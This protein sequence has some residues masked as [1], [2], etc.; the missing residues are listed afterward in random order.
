MQIWMLYLTTFVANAA[1]LIFEI[2][3]ARFLAPYIGTSYEVWAGLISVILGS[4]AF[5]YWLGGRIADRGATRKRLAGIVFLA[6]G[7]GI[8]MWSVREIVPLLGMALFVSSPIIFSAIVI[9][10]ILFAP[11]TICLAI[12]SPY[13]VK[14]AL[15]N[16]SETARVVGTLSAIGTIGSIVGA[17]FVS[18]F[19]I[20]LFGISS[21]LLGTS[22]SLLALGGLL[23]LSLLRI[24]PFFFLALF[25]LIALIIVGSIPLPDGRIAEASTPYNRI[26]VK[27]GVVN[28]VQARYVQLDPYG[29]QCVM[30]FSGDNVDEMRLVF[31]YTRA[32]GVAAET[33]L[34]D[35]ENP[36]VLFLGG[37]VYT[38]PRWLSRVYKNTAFDVVEIDPGMTRVAK[39]YFG[40]DTRAHPEISIFHEDARQFL[41]RED[42][43]YDIIFMD[44][45]GSSLNIPH[46]LSTKE[47]FASLRDHL[48]QRGVL[49]VN[50]I[51]GFE[52]EKSRF[53][54]SLLTTVRAVFPH[55]S[56]YRI[57][58]NKHEDLQNMILIASSYEL[59]DT[60]SSREGLLTLFHEDV[61][62]VGALLL[63]DEY[64]P[65]EVLLDPI[66]R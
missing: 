59:P 45:F 20:P 22:L 66:R 60:L 10:F 26:I 24:K 61:D 42:S 15:T 38:F 31:P 35:A 16:L 3:G 17:V 57:G 44:V 54:T 27:E 4:M 6:G 7:M 37:C 53:P 48:R 43:L 29:I 36:R 9:G 55:A 46:H 64:A 23:S 12:V 62:E 30:P 50:V 63:T 65:V 21:I 47:A 19:F 32:F 33:F 8:L 40:F 14:L 1:I 25:V 18:A 51:G 11:V 28:D 5:G 49:V 56:L 13:I 34:A 58:A 41:R 39:Q 52:G 2:A